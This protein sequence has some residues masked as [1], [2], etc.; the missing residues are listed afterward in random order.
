MTLQFTLVSEYP[1]DVPIIEMIESVN[2]DDTDEEDIF[3][4][5]RDNAK[6]NVGMV[7]IFTLVSN[8][9]E[10][11]NQLND[12]KRCEK[13]EYAERKKK[14]EE[15]I[16]MKKFEGTRVTVE[17]FMTWKFDCEI[18]KLR[19]KD[20]LSVRS[21]VKKLTGRELFEKDRTL[22][23]SDLQF[24]DDVPDDDFGYDG[25]RVDESLF[26]NFDDMDLEGIDNEP[27]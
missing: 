23:E 7:M 5:L 12:R 27:L 9:I 24:L 22:F 13:I 10:W 2:L 11:I 3:Q 6:N 25:V 17:S 14:E 16:E 26:E 1:D 19:D 8:A 21:D 18:S 15:E 4:M 20:Q